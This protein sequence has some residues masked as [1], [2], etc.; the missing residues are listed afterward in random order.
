MNI[1]FAS[2]EVAPFAKTGGLADVSYSFPKALKRLGDEISVITPLYKTTV[3][4][5]LNLTKIKELR[6]PHLNELVNVEVFKATDFDDFN[7]LFINYAPYFDRDCLYGT[8]KNEF[9][10]NHLRYMLFSRSILEYIQSIDRP[11]EI[12]HL[13]DWH[14]GLV[15]PYLDVYYKDKL[16]KV[17]TVFTIHNLGY[18]GRDSKDMIKTIGLPDTYLSEEMLGEDSELATIKG[19]F[20]CDAVNTVSPTYA[21]EITTPEFGFDLDDDLRRIEY[22]LTGILNGIDYELWDPNTD[23]KI[24]ANYNKD[25]FERKHTVCKLQLQKGLGLEVNEDSMLCGIVSRLA[26]QKGIDI[27]TEMLEEKVPENTQFVILGT[28]EET[29]HKSLPDIALKNKDRISVVLGFD[30]TLAR[31]IY[32]GCDVF[33][34]PS[35]YEPCGLSQMIAM[36][37]GTVPIAR[38]TGGL[39]DTIIDTN[40]QSDIISNGS[41]GFLFDDYSAISFR[42]AIERA[43]ALFLDKKIWNN[44]ISNCFNQ[45]FSWDS[46]AKKYLELYNKIKNQ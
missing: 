36:A 9:P 32:A 16:S 24:E 8:E 37:Y 33:L 12:I 21:K 3:E 5:G 7:T 1:L 40:N 20:M 23:K 35:H 31:R 38:K 25:N 13:N 46:S 22:K 43:Q 10:D 4:T 44:L 27:L 18:Q 28:G 34:L 42:R 19:G 39:A 15:K 26:S 41:T 6:V 30:S 29:Y 17:K 11:P 2:S 45:N 14:T